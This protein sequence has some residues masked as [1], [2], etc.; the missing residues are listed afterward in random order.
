MIPTQQNIVLEHPI[1][2]IFEYD[3]EQ[4]KYHWLQVRKSDYP[5]FLLDKCNECDS[6]ICVTLKT[7]QNT[8]HKM[9]LDYGNFQENHRYYIKP[10]KRRGII[11]KQRLTILETADVHRI[12][13][14][15][16][17]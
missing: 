12:L 7:I 4:E 17:N 11:N 6:P 8:L 1:E 14:P 3:I 15:Y 10:L 16:K 2:R 13:N 9:Y 5:I